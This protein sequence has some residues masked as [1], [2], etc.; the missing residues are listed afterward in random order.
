MSIETCLAEICRWFVLMALLAAAVGKSLRFASF[1]ESVGEGFPVLGRSGAPMA[2]AVIV[3]A[4]WLAAGLILIG[5]TVSRIGVLLAL[6]LFVSL[7]LVVT[8]VLAK[9]M[10]VRC[11][12][13]GASQ[14]RIS[15][16]DLGRNLLFIAAAC[17]A[18][19]FAP[20]PADAGVSGGLPLAAALPIATIAL[21]LLHLSLHLRDLAHLMQV[22][23]EDL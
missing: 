13:F 3:G 4:E 15:G 16:F 8:V 17:G 18:L 23:A 7:T 11:N 20:F 21:M 2:A 10:S 5:G 9:G 22:R 19:R 12:C 14:Q 6:A 1:R